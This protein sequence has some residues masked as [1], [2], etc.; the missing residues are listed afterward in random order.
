[1][2]KKRLLLFVCAFVPLLATAQLNTDRISAIG[3]NALYFDDFVLSIQYFNQVI[4]LKPWLA[5]P[6]LYRAIAKIQLADLT[7]ALQDCNQALQNN[8]FLPGAYYT[9]G[10][11]ERANQHFEQA[12]A[13]FT[14][15]LVFSPENATYLLLRADVRS[16]QKDFAG[17]LQDIDFLLRRDPNNGSLYFEKGAICLNNQ[18]TLQALS[19][20]TQAIRFDALNASTWSA[21][22]LVNLLLEHEP[23]ALEDLNEAIRLGSKWSGDFINRG[24]L[25]YK[26]HN[27]RAALADYDQAI[28]YDRQEPQAYYNR[29][30][31]RAELGDY[32]RALD[33]LNQALA[34]QPSATEMRYQRGMVNLQLRQ[35]D[36][37]VQDFDSLIATYPYFLP[38]YYLAAQAKRESGNSKAAFRYQ[39]QAY[40]LEK[41]KDDIQAHHPA[42]NTD[43]Q[44]ASNRPT[45]KDRR[46][47]FS[48]LAAQNQEDDPE[49][50]KYTSQARGRV[51]NKYADVINEPNIELSYYA[52]PNS[53]RRTNYFHPSL[54]A[55]NRLQVLPAP[56]RLVCHEVALTADLVGTHFESITRLSDLIDDASTSPSSS[57]DLAD[58]YFARALESALVQDYSSALDDITQA[59]V[60]RSDWGLAYFCRANWRYK[61][62]EYN[63]SAGIAK[64]PSATPSASSFAP[65]DFELILRDLDKTIALLPDFAFAYYNKANVLCLQKSYREAL[66]AYSAALTLDADF[67]EAYF[68]RGLTYIFIDEVDLGI[69]DLSKAGENGIYQAYNL[70]TRLK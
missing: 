32:N 58:L 30:L 31:L 45:Q 42:V 27:F 65:L 11:V 63:R 18:D 56:L 4:K 2:K 40:E 67:A 23:E 15:A 64:S 47:E 25:L 19:Q 20:F 8:P 9:R 16:Q 60:L 55:Y 28:L 70:I 24:I 48:T 6:Y 7:G 44:V 43:V 34:L 66:A 53:L 33:D 49:T 22:G 29:A 51:Q 62:Y 35:W 50:L 57:T 10:F 12:E 68:N 3:R 1:M 52:N 61:L 39:Q 46:K 17:A 38:S 5:E 14:Q 36:D 54:E 21:R 37:A 59:L 13:D 26:Q 69:A 41:H